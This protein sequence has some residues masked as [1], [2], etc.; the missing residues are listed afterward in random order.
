MSVC[1]SS[2]LPQTVPCVTTF[3]VALPNAFAIELSWCGQ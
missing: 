1:S 3:F 2:P